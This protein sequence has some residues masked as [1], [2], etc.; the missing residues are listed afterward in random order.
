[1]STL[2]VSFSS[3]PYN[4]L[5]PQIQYYVECND[6]ISNESSSYLFFTLKINDF[7]DW[8]IGYETVFDKITNKDIPMSVKVEKQYCYNLS[9]NQLA[10]KI[11]NILLLV[12]SSNGIIYKDDSYQNLKTSDSF[13]YYIYEKGSYTVQ[14]K[15]LKVV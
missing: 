1:M 7:K 8:F 9:Y 5:I 15:L 14:L 10:A 12:R 4:S 2:D 3:Q 6:K 11:L 13:D